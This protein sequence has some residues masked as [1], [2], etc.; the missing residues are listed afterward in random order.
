MPCQALMRVDA[1]CVAKSAPRGP[2]RHHPSRQRGPQFESRCR[3]P[4][5]T[6]TIAAA[7]APPTK[8]QIH[9]ANRGSTGLSWQTNAGQPG[10]VR[11]ANQSPSPTPTGIAASLRTV[12]MRV[13]FIQRC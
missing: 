8:A 3:M 12:L 5:E 2:R 1:G 11:S 9:G 10:T 6:R 7:A 13:G 4:I